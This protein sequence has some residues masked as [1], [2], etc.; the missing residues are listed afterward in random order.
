[1]QVGQVNT[2]CNDSGD[3]PLVFTLR[4]LHF[5]SASQILFASYCVAPFPMML[6]YS[7]RSCA[8]C[9][10]DSVRISKFFSEA[11]SVSLQCFF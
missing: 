11:L 10:Q 6:H 4:S 3:D 9:S 8:V 1:M 7:V 2:S 5:L